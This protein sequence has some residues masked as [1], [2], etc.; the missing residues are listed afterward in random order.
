[1]N[2]LTS[3]VLVIIAVAAAVLYLSTYTVAEWQTAIKFRLGEIVE[4]DMEPGLHFKTPFITR[5]RTFDAR[6]QTL[7]EEPQRFLTVEQKNVIVDSFVKWR[8]GDVR[9]YYLT[10]GGDPE[11]ANLR[12]SEIIRN[13][14]RNEFGQRTV[15]Q[16][17]SGDRSAIVDTLREQ[18]R[19]A[20]NALGMNVVDL[21]IRRIDLPED[22]SESV[23]RRMVAEREQV[24]RE[25]RAEGQE[26]AE[27]IR[28]DADRQRAVLLAEARRD[29][30]R[31]RGEGDA[32]AAAIYAEAYTRAPE[33]FRF[34][35]S[36]EA[37]RNSFDGDGNLLVLSPDSPFFRYFDSLE[38]AGEQ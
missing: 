33:F 2:R 16:V 17:V 12:L 28:A 30:Q 18:T 36:L 10:V 11:R 27:R 21:R 7:D 38:P 26:Q 13:G 23:F 9:Q 19:K 32:A 35:R 29:A 14:L 15:Q 5:V 24:A 3:V 34:Y 31:I 6:V 20:A 22:V 4:T 37:Y 1:M 25:F 8:I